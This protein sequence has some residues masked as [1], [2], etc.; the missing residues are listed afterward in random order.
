MWGRVLTRYTI[1]VRNEDG[2][3]ATHVGTYDAPTVAEAI[4]QALQR[5][6]QAWSCDPSKLSVFGIAEGDLTAPHRKDE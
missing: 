1:W 6:A 3:L 4:Q 5:V 2:A